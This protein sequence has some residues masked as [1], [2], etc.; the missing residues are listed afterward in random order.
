MTG[1][2]H[3]V[4]TY[5]PYWPTLPGPSLDSVFTESL[6]SKKGQILAKIYGDSQLSLNM[7][8]YKVSNLLGIR[9]IKL[10]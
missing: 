6:L 4:A 3:V 2:V 7:A 1:K 5:K 10:K 9:I 8:V